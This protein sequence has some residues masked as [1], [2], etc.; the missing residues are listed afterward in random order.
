ME[1]LTR[2][3]SGNNSPLKRF[4]SAPVLSGD[5]LEQATRGIQEDFPEEGIIRLPPFNINNASVIRNGVSVP[6]SAKEFQAIQDNVN[7]SLSGYPAFTSKELEDELNAYEEYVKRQEEQAEIDGVSPVVDPYSKCGRRYPSKHMSPLL[8]IYNPDFVSEDSD[9]DSLSQ[10]SSTVHIPLGT[11][12]E[13]DGVIHFDTQS[14]D[15][16]ITRSASLPQP[17]PEPVIRVPVIKSKPTPRVKAN[18][19]SSASVSGPV[20]IPASVSASTSGNA[21]VVAKKSAPSSAVESISPVV[22]PE[23]TSLGQVVSDAILAA[24]STSGESMRAKGL[25][26]HEY[27]HLTENELEEIVAAQAITGVNIRVRISV[28]EL[29]LAPA[30][31]VLRSLDVVG[32][33]MLVLVSKAKGVNDKWS[34]PIHQD[35]HDVLN[36]VDCNVFEEDIDAKGLI[37]SASVWEGVGKFGLRAADPAKVDRWRRCLASLKFGDLDWNSFPVD[38]LIS[39]KKQVSILLRSELK[40]FKLKWLTHGLL[41]GNRLLRGRIEA[42]YSRTYDKSSATRLGVSKAGWRLVFAEIDEAFFSSME[43]YPPGYSFFLGSSTVQLR[44]I[45]DRQCLSDN[46]RA[47]PG[48]SGLHPGPSSSLAELGLQEICSISQP[49]PLK[50]LPK[51]GRGSRGGKTGTSSRRGRGKTSTSSSTRSATSAGKVMTTRKRSKNNSTIS[52]QEV[53]AP[54]NLG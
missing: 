49:V 44:V 1:R 12:T 14:S 29:I 18:V 4:S 24:R 11:G 19:S 54:M 26:P 36:A 20:P 32:L 8:K 42:K 25:V 10:S 7:K 33:L 53:A 9:G 50:S 28:P 45:Q 22:C 51:S 2:P 21:I 38:A 35:F 30:P 40:N 13:I 48:F 39:N 46:L 43:R 17:V 52:A 27:P 3:G 31:E 15:T 34:I 6:I 23:I 16:S 37:S 41:L 47:T 5:L